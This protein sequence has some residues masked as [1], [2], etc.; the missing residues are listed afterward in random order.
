MNT[1]DEDTGKWVVTTYFTNEPSEVYGFFDSDKEAY[2]WA[3]QMYKAQAY[4]VKMVLNAHY[5]D[6]DP[7]DYRGMGW[8]DDK[9]RP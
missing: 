3:E 6:E 9:G 7:N 4:D 8:V 1:N 5:Q 2:A